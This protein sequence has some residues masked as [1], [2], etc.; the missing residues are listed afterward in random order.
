MSGFLNRV[1]LIGNLGRDPEVRTMQ[2][3]G[4]VVTLSIA[5]SESWK[6]ERS[7]ERRER[8]EWHRVVI[9][10]CYREFATAG[11]SN[12]G[13]P[14]AGGRRSAGERC[15][16]RRAPR[17]GLPVAAHRRRSARDGVHRASRRARPEPQH[18]ACLRAG[19][20]ESDRA[21]GAAR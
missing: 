2:S 9:F 10:I 21:G 11:A 20:R 13:R 14:T 12:V 18:P 3:G 4:R 16:G 17:L 8:T 19:T 5:T 6:D 15:R 7:G 1:Q